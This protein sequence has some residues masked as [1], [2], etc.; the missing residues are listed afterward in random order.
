MSQED[1]DFFEEDELEVSRDTQLAKMFDED[2]KKTLETSFGRAVLHRLIFA[3]S[4]GN[5]EGAPSVENPL[6]MAFAS[7]KKSVALKLLRELRRI[8]KSLV[9]LAEDEHD[10]RLQAWKGL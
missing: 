5:L 2:L 9:R 1:D 6:H 7:G 10:A 3:P 8:D 4:L